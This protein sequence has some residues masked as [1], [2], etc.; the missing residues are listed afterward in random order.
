MF[1]STRPVLKDGNLCINGKNVL[2]GVPDN[3]IVTPY[4]NTSAFVG[5][6]SS[7]N[8]A[9][10]VFKLGIIQDVRLLCIFRFKIWWMIPR[11]GNSGSDIPVETQMLLLEARKEPSSDASDDSPSY[12]LFLPVLDGE[13]RS[14]LQGNS[15]DELELCVESGDPSTVTS[16]TLQAVFVNFGDHPFDLVKESMKWVH[17]LLALSCNWGQCRILEKY[18]GTFAHRETKQMPG[19]LDWFGWCTWDAF[20]TEVNPKGI[21]DGLKRLV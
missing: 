19:M 17:N 1:I 10:H 12:I 20:Y 14:S 9:R 2:T 3:V 7:E 21:K 4:N 8:R 13:F 16:E 18:C 5:A 11:M 6:T 15:L